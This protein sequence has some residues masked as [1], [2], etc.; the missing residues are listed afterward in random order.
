MMSVSCTIRAFLPVHVGHQQGC[1]LSPVLFGAFMNRISCQKGLVW[2]PQDPGHQVILLAWAGGEYEVTGMGLLKNLRS[3]VRKGRSVRRTDRFLSWKVF[4]TCPTA[5]STKI[6]IFSETCNLF[7]M[8]SH[9]L[10][11]ISASK[12]QNKR[13]N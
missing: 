13:G 5:R 6:C 8:I 11:K 12:Q 1:P 10:L 4:R 9:N 3:S 2:A 7:H